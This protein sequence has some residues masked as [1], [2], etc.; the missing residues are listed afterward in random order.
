MADEQITASKDTD[1][2]SIVTLSLSILTASLGTTIANVALPTLTQYFAAPFHQIQWI[3]IGYLVAMTITV[4]LAGRL[5]DLFGLKRMLVL[6]MVI[7]S[8]AS[9]L[10]ALAPDLWLLVG[11]R[12]LQGIGGAFMMTLTVAL[13]SQIASTSSIGRAMG[14]LGTMLA[15]GTA[16]GPLLGGLLI[17][18]TG[19]RALFLVL[20]GLGLLATMM[21]IYCLPPQEERKDGNT[22][23]RKSKWFDLPTTAIMR[24]LA[25]IVANAAVAA[26]MMTTLVVGPFYLGFSLDLSEAIIGLVMAV[27]PVISIF[28][29][30][31]SG[32]LVD[33]LGT[34]SVL[35]IGLSTLILGSTIFVIVPDGPNIA[36]YCLA[37]AVLAV[38]YQLF[39]AA[40]NTAV[41]VNMPP[42][43]R[44]TASG[45]LNLSRNIGLIFG[46]SAM[47]A[48][49]AFGVGS[50]AI[51]NATQQQITDGLQLTFGLA[52]AM[53]IMAFWMVCRQ[54]SRQQAH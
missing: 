13:M 28:S 19:W 40:N 31:P 50:G 43:E 3:V 39:Q 8:G 16:L 38:G 34:Q 5:G 14:L 20:L 15:V 1:W 18:T 11:A 23:D 54:R 29:G 53:I 46:A 42:D 33:V 12:M 2:P 25:N 52:A 36:F 30:V 44:G 21:T 32:K 26:V 22:P 48:I 49:F 45:L 7:F 27:G 4:V 10:C 17:Q 41:M 51:E 6:G 35:T 24:N 47:G 37:I 9:L